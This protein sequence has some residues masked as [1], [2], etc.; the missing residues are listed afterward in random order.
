[1]QKPL[2]YAVHGFFGVAADWDRVS[3]DLPGYEF[4]GEELFSHKPHNGTGNLI[5]TLAKTDRKKI[6]LGYS[7]GGRL[8]LRMLKSNPGQFDH[9][10][11]L[12]THPGLTDQLSREQRIDSDEQWAAKINHENW[13]TLLKAW[14]AQAVFEG[15]GPEP[16]RNVSDYD[17]AKLRRALMEWSLGRQDDYSEL[18]REHRQKLTWAVGDRDLKFCKI[19]D[20]LKNKKILS[21]FERIPSGHR[22]WLDQP[23]AIVELI[24][25]MGL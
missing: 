19:A 20:D 18:I 11:F 1:M 21:D 5:S 13:Q 17:L 15:S 8:G 22:I 14:N 2:V 16:V 4:I 9:Y 25:K 24:K 3:A 12:S 10:I 6:F 23:K 7:L